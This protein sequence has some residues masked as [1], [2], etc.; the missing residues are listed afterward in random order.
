MKQQQE[1][2]R[3]SRTG[4]LSKLSDY[5]CGTGKPPLAH[6]FPVFRPLREN[7]TPTS[8]PRMSQQLILESPLSLES[9]GPFIL[10]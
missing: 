5:F 3:R 1:V 6:P 9:F 8:K 4:L 10:I 2:R 7:F